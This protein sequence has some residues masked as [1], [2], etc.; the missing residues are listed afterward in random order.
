MSLVI[1]DFRPDDVGALVETL[2]DEWHFD[3]YGEGWEEVVSEYVLEYVRRSDASRVAELDGT[4]V[5]IATVR[6]EVHE[7]DMAKVDELCEKYPDNPYYRDQRTLDHADAMLRSENDLTGLGEMVLLI[8]S[9]RVRG[10]HIGRRLMDEAS[11]LLAAR[12]CTGMHIA[13]DTECNYGF[14]EHLGARRLGETECVVQG[15]PLVRYLYRLDF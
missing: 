6:A 2:N 14:Y 10:A 1:R 8:V 13:T 9:G 5:G 12:G 7:G 15:K 3:L 4:V 11:S